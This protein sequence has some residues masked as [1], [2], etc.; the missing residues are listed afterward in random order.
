ME[1]DGKAA[2]EGVDWPG[3]RSRVPARAEEAKNL[4]T[5]G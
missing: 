5:W 3:A 4:A 1:L 2:S